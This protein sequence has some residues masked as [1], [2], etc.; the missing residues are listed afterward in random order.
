MELYGT[1]GGFSA[2]WDIKLSC[3]LG[4]ACAVPYASCVIFQL[5]P[6]LVA[7]A[8]VLLSCYIKF[9]RDAVGFFPS[10]FFHLP[11]VWRDH[12]AQLLHQDLQ[13]I[14]TQ[15]V[16]QIRAACR[17]RKWRREGGEKVGEISSKN[18]NQ[19]IFR[20][21]VVRQASP[22]RP[23]E[24]CYRLHSPLSPRCRYTLSPR[25]ALQ[26]TG[27]SVPW[28][29]SETDFGQPPSSG[30]H[31]EGLW[32]GVVRKGYMCSWIIYTSIPSQSLIF[33]LICQGLT[34]NIGLKGI[35][36]LNKVLLRYWGFVCLT[37]I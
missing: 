30:C 12:M 24:L 34:N 28:P 18:K 7:T 25:S 15:A 17:R 19:R 11:T 36:Q 9:S 13:A 29:C 22:P 35:I 20:A 1:Q 4:R 26:L 21:C 33:S 31:W 5:F 2:K 6:L 10:G 32:K 14:P 16:Y 23:H 27:S 37:S 8:V 3:L